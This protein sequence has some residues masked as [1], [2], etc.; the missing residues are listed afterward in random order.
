VTELGK[1]GRE[2][3]TLY[4]LD[5]PTTGLHGE[6]VDRLVAV[7]RRLVARGDTVVVIEH[8]LDVVAASDHVI[9]LGPEGGD[10]GGRVIVEGTP[11]EVA[12]S[13]GPTGAALAAYFARHGT[14]PDAGRGRPR[15]PARAKAARGASAV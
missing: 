9:D 10:A 13:R 7:L 3:K 6:D 4:V 15:G 14:A 5:E 11:A 1:T 12:A 2:G 8:N